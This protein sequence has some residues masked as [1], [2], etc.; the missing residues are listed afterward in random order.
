MSVNR[1]DPRTPMLRLMRVSGPPERLEELT[2]AVERAGYDLKDAFVDTTAEYGYPGKGD[3]L[4][5]VAFLLSDVAD[6]RAA[7]EAVPVDALERVRQAAELTSPDQDTSWIVPGGFWVALP[8][9][10]P[11]GWY[12]KVLPL[13]ER[14]HGAEDRLAH[15]PAPPTTRSHWWQRG[16]DKPPVDDAWRDVLN[17]RDVLLDVLAH[18]NAVAGVNI[19]KFLGTIAWENGPLGPRHAA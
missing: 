5:C 7:F 17:S 2:C 12:A 15:T 4:A 1:L 11:P 19:A 8:D 13:I 3:G 18:G 10:L 6:D 9:A 14:L 16:S